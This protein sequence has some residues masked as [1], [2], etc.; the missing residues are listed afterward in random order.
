MHKRNDQDF[1]KWA[2]YPATANE[3][4]VPFWKFQSKSTNLFLDANNERCYPHQ[5]NSSHY[6][7][8]RMEY[9]D[10]SREWFHLINRATGKYLSVK[11]HN[12]RPFG[13][14]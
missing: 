7:E 5:G 2:I 1:Q 10:D 14:M 3:H 11:L 9:L 13:A 4:G 12:F 8:W 6:Q